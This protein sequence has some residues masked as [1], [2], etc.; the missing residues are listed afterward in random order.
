MAADEP[1]MGIDVSKQ[2]LDVVVRPAGTHRR[3]P[4]NA[5]G[6]ARLCQQVQTQPP[7]RIVLEASGG[8]EQEVTLALAEAGMPPVL[9]NPLEVRY[10]ARSQGRKAK[11]DRVDAGVLAHFGTERRPAPTPLPGGVAREARA[12]LT[13]R[14][15]LT[16]L[17]AMEKTRRHRA[18]TPAV[19]ASLAVTIPFLSDQRKA[20]DQELA[21]VVARDADLAARVAQLQTVPGLSVYSA[22]VLAVEVPELG[23][24]PRRQ[25]CSLLG[26]APF[27]CESGQRARARRISGGR[28]EVRHLLYAVILTTIR[29]DA[30]FAA[31][32]QRW[33]HGTTPK[34]V[35]VARIACIR[36]FL[37]ILT[38]M[39]R[40]GL[41]WQ[42]TEVG[43]GRFL[44]TAT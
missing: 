21:A 40:D 36:K 10:F 26:V 39:L 11:T 18:T 27:A 31:Y 20:L 13:R 38:A 9:A 28:A 19:Q 1:V 5:A 22:T 12:L 37:G 14:R 7:A 6:W 17:L 35:K 8:Y 23:T 16:Q 34:P 15:Q 33:R 3:V 25:L 41:T 24:H 32:Y 44:A 2:W 29:C 30:T 42:E 43:Q 4:N